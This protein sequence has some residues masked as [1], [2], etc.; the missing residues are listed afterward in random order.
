MIIPYKLATRSGVE[1]I[2]RYHVIDSSAKGSGKLNFCTYWR[3][4]K[5]IPN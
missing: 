1:S 5:S 3:P 4:T 2:I